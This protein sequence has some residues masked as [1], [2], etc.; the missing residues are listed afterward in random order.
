MNNPSDFIE[1]LDHLLAERK[2][3]RAL[4]RQR[5]ITARLA[6][7][8]SKVEMEIAELIEKPLSLSKRERPGTPSLVL[9][10]SDLL[11]NYFSHPQ[12]I[13]EPR[14]PWSSGLIASTKTDGWPDS[15]TERLT[16]LCAPLDRLLAERLERESTPLQQPAT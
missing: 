14:Y 10:V 13:E 8:V 16:V 5:I 15:L 11:H 1:W 7:N 2:Q 4:V 6:E 9:V 12:S 3:L